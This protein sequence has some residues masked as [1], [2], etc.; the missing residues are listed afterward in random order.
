LYTEEEDDDDRSDG[1]EAGKEDDDKEQGASS[2][3]KEMEDPPV[4]DAPEDENAEQGTE[5]D[6]GALF[7]IAAQKKEEQVEDKWKRLGVDH[8]TTASKVIPDPNLKKDILLM[9]CLDNSANTEAEVSTVKLRKLTIGNIQCYICDY[10]PVDLLQKMVWFHRTKEF[11]KRYN[12]HAV[13]IDPYDVQQTEKEVAALKA[14]QQ[15][16][17]NERAKQCKGSYYTYY[18]KYKDDNSYWY[19]KGFTGA[20]KEMQV[21]DEFMKKIA[22]AVKAAKKEE[23][24]IDIEFQ[25]MHGVAITTTQGADH[26]KAHVDTEKAFYVDKDAPEKRAYIGHMPL[27]SEGIVLRLENL[28]EQML[29]CLK[30][31][32]GHDAPVLDHNSEV[33]QDHLYLHIPFG[34]ILLIDDRTFHGGHYGTAGKHRFHF[35][36]SPY[37]WTPWNKSKKNTISRPEEMNNADKK[38]DSL[39]FLNQAARFYAGAEPDAPAGSWLEADD[40]QVDPPNL[41]TE[42]HLDLS[43]I[44]NLKAY[45]HKRGSFYAKY[46]AAALVGNEELIRSIIDK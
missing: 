33:V 18:S 36:L 21:V 44:S 26:Q 29:R 12:N 17:Q 25:E 1:D 39:Q 16:D 24:N 8:W 28:T 10:V 14:F 34:S 45:W 3:E 35:V 42:E 19:E 41:V 2:K 32:E 9:P 23:L 27:Q 46:A 15:M 30:A 5:P 31:P 38:G 40:P 37:D 22:E 20:E 7:E 13:L 6:V 4:N 11:G 43:K